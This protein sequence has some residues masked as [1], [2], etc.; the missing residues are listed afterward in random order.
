MSFADTAVVTVKAGN[1]GNGIVS[2]RHEKFVDRGGPDGGD[3]GDGGDVIFR[4][5][6]NVNTLSDFR[7]HRELKA[8]NG[9]SGSKRKRHGK[10]GKDLELVVPVGTSVSE[11][12]R[13]VADLTEVGQTAV[14]ANG[15]RGGFGNAHFTSSR[16]Q[17]PR[18]AEK[19]ERGQERTLQLELKLIADVG[20]VGLPNA[21]K[22]TF[23]SVVSNARPQIADYPFTTLV[24]HLGVADV[25]KT[26]LLFAD[27]PGLIEGASKGKGLGDEFLRHIERTAV[28]LHVI[29]VYANDIAADYLTVVKELE[30]YRLDLTAKPRIIAVNKIDGLDEDIVANQVNQLKEVA[31][32][33]PIFTIS[34]QAKKGLKPLLHQLV[35]T[36]RLA[37]EQAKVEAEDEQAEE[38]QTRV[39]Q[40]T[41]SDDEWQITKESKKY[42]RVTGKKI[43]GFAQRTDFS[44]NFGVERL[45]DIMFKM[46]IVQELESMG[47]E[48]GH[49]ILFG[50]TDEIELTL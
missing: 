38:R 45:R 5:D 20:L 10:R 3:G 19:G 22:S 44:N 11:D 46:G 32:D 13:Q 2:F 49:H 18:V 48:T 42:Y 41:P 9:Q 50:D 29:D 16:R 27:I 25:G 39:I 30:R 15:G 26:S 37:R 7:H 21:G 12:G 33:V 43:E 31:G 35:E 28:L 47:A 36:A 8:E 1:G 24:P 6:Q 4:A 40:L 14:I 34:T 17:A 23:L